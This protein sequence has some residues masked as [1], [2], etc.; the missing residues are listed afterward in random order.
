MKK[1][2]LFTLLLLLAG[3][4]AACGSAQPAV[5]PAG[6]TGP[7]GPQGPAGQPGPPGPPG[8]AGESATVSE[9]NFV[10]DETCA[11]CHQDTYDTYIKSGHPWIMSKIAEGKAPAFPFQQIK[12]PPQGYT[13]EDILYVVGGYNWKALFVNKEGYFITEEPGK[14]GSAEYGNQWNLANEE[15]NKNAGWVSYHAGEANLGH[16]CAE[17]HTTGFNPGSSQDNLAGNSGSWAQEGVRCEACHGPGGQHMTNPQVFGMRIERDQAAC[18]GCHPHTG[19]ENLPV[20]DGF[21]AHTDQYA[22]LHQGKHAVLDCV[23]C[24]DPHKG[25]AQARQAGEPT[26]RA[27]CVQCHFQ[28]AQRQKVAAHKAMNMR[29]IECHM[30]KIIASAWDDPAKF[31]GDVRTHRMAIDPTQL[32]QVSEDGATLLPQIGLNSACR[33]CHVPNGP[34]AKTDE[35]LLGAAAGYHDPQPPAATP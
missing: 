8:P 7:I 35:Q 5:G 28:Q 12:D 23:T 2:W 10:G 19:P 13:W 3:A 33:H 27:E 26:V 18:I 9:V 31:T 15:L 22:D 4:L 14:S 17:C 24:H 32:S 6:P 30:P 1:F 16:A 11:G 25:V 29:C 20:K 21:I 34:T